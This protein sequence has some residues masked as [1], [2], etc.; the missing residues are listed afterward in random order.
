MESKKSCV[1]VESIY[2][3]NIPWHLSSWYLL[4]ELEVLYFAIKY[5]IV[6]NLFLE[7]THI[8]LHLHILVLK[9]SS[10]GSVSI[11]T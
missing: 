1:G 2:E 6:Q 8:L 4:V 3:S 9:K 10:C 7:I 5:Q 11:S